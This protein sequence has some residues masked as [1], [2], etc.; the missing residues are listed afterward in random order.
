MSAAPR[1]GPACSVVGKEKVKK[2]QKKK[3]GLVGYIAI[4]ILYSIYKV[5]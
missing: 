1:R 3:K 5:C 2:K 4:L